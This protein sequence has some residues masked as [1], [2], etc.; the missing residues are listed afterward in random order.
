M[1]NFVDKNFSRSCF[2]SYL[3]TIGGSDKTTYRDHETMI[4]RE[5]WTFSRYVTIRRRIRASLMGWWITLWKKKMVPRQSC[6]AWSQSSWVWRRCSC[7]WNLPS[8]TGSCWAVDE[9]RFELKQILL[10]WSSIETGSIELI[11]IGTEP[12]ELILDWNRFYWVGL[13]LNGFRLTNFER[14]IEEDSQWIYFR[15][16][17]FM[18]ISSLLCSYLKWNSWADFLIT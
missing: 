5:N 16:I 13:N 8:S 1:E 4:L 11:W 17:E 15:K 6:W 18:N 12:A 14:Q 7:V 2:R 3:E 9:S 10:S